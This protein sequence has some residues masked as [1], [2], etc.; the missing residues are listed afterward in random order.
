MRKK[1][2]DDRVMEM[3]TLQES[4]AALLD[5]KSVTSGRELFKERMHSAILSRRSMIM[6]RNPDTSMVGA[7]AKAL[8]ELWG[9]ADQEHWE[10]E[11]ESASVDVHKFVNFTAKSAV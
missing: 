5:L 8:A 1:L 7:Y 4:A 10:S 9:E 2:I 3:K 11:A 6:L